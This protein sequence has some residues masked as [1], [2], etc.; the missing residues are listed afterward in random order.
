MAGQPASSSEGPWR[1]WSSAP[2]WKERDSPRHRRGSSSA[3]NTA[4]TSSRVARPC[5][6]QMARESRATRGRRK[7]SR[8]SS[9]TRPRM[10]MKLHS[11]CRSRVSR[12]TKSQLWS[13]VRPR[14][15]SALHSWVPSVRQ[16]SYGMYAYLMAIG[17]LLTNVPKYISAMSR[18][19]KPL[20]EKMQKSTSANSCMEHCATSN[21]NIFSAVPADAPEHGG[22]MRRFLRPVTEP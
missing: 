12:S 19:L 16:T 7:Q 2:S 3:N 6:E 1:R 20:G 17:T 15:R 11:V 5:R 14:R 4:V 21:A 22:H 13:S 9:P 18:A 10:L 8:G